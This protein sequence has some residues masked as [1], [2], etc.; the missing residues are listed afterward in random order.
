MTLTLGLATVIAAGAIV[1]YDYTHPGSESH[2]RD[3]IILVAILT[4]VLPIAVAIVILCDTAADWL[5]ESPEPF[6]K[7]ITDE[8]GKAVWADSASS[9]SFARSI[10]RETVSLLPS[11]FEIKK[12]GNA[13]EF[14]EFRLRLVS[15]LQSASLLDPIYC[16]SHLNLFAKPDGGSQPTRDRVAQIN[17]PFFERLSELALEG[18]RGGLRLILQYTDDEVDLLEKELTDRLAI[19]WKIAREREKLDWADR[20]FDVTR[21]VATMSKDYFVIGDH[22]FKTIRKTERSRQAASHMYIRNADIA[23]SY[24]E[25]MEDLF[26]YGHQGGKNPSTDKY[27]IAALFEKIKQSQSAG[28]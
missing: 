9:D 12:F 5:R 14:A 26:Y 2:E 25:W 4:L 18:R 8:V 7:R 19:F 15:D 11:N 6:A 10:A 1:Y 22:I 24:R 23:A 17:R 21:M 28:K 20:E 16:T 13:V 3:H 27:G